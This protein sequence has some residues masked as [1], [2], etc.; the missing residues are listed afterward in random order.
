M[1]TN[2]KPEFS[3]APNPGGHHGEITTSEIFLQDIGF[4]MPSKDLKGEKRKIGINSV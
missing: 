2:I 4:V 3:D 1:V